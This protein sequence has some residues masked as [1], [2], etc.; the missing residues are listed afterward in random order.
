ML[1]ACEAAFCATPT[2]SSR[3]STCMLSELKKQGLE[4]LDLA[5][6][7]VRPDVAEAVLHEP[8]DGGEP[9]V[10]EVLR[11][12]YTWKGKVLRPAMVKVAARLRDASGRATRVVREGLLQGP[13]RRRRRRAEGHHQGLPQAGAREL[14][15]DKHPGDAAAEERFKEVSAAYDVLGDE[16]KRK[17]YDEVR[18]LGPM[19]GCARRRWPGP[20]GIRLQRR[21]HGRAGGSATCSAA[22]SAAAAAAA[23]R[24]A[25]PARSAAPTSRPTLTL[26][27]A[28]AAHGITTTLHLTSDAQCSTCHGSGAKPGTQ[29]KRV[30][31]TAADV[32]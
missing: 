20:G 30:L 25:A 29:P 14:H 7:A 22:C 5:R 28:D 6:A 23:R 17:E 11:T 32:A 1:D 2:R 4:A 21:R 10:S 26:D 18:R 12:G 9:V 8:G 31:A 27:F 15:P 24:S 16:A 3:C 13:R 19:G